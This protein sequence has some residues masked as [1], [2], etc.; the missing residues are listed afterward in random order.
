MKLEAEVTAGLVN[1]IKPDAVILATGG[2]PFLPD[3]PGIEGANVV[4]ADDVLKGTAKVG[5]TVVIVGGGMVGCETAD[6]LSDLGKKVTVL[7]MLPELAPTVGMRMRARL[8]ERLAEKG[9]KLETKARCT[10][11]KERDVL[12]RNEE[13]KILKVEADTVVLAV[14]SK[15]NRS[16]Y[17]AIGNLVPETYLLGDS[18]EPRQ[19]LEAVTEGFKIGSTI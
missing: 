8:L 1:T 18:L 12:Y 6:F 2:I 15:P 9:V 16:L 17:S 11:I 5:P 10:G 14:G 13:G 3:I 7:E 4:M 19:I